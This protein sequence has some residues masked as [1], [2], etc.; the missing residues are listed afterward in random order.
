MSQ[1]PSSVTNLRREVRVDAC[2]TGHVVRGRDR[3]PFETSDVSFKGFGFRT[4]QPPPIRSLVRFRLMLPS[5]EIEAHAMVVHV[6][7]VGVGVQ[8][9]GL[10]GNERAAWEATV[11]ELH[12]RKGPSSGVLATEPLRKSG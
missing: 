8:F 7:P 4:H 6:S 12:K 11:Q 2:I 9:W 1:P 10:S 5:G 3:I